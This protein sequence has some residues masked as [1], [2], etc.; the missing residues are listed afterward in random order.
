VTLAVG[1]GQPISD[2][3]AMCGKDMI[4]NTI[5]ACKTNNAYVKLANDNNCKELQA[6]LQLDKHRF[7][8][9]SDLMKT[10]FANLISKENMQNFQALR[11]P[12]RGKTNSPALVFTV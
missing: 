5:Q 7:K 1:R 4:Y 3:M 8:I 11:E 10:N 2:N 9:K 12:W 6:F